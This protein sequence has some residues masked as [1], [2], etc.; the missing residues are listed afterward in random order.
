MVFRGLGDERL[1]PS[2]DS[3][4]AGSTIMAL[5]GRIMS[6]STKVAALLIIR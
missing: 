4:S 3:S 2:H 1:A 5:S 6:K